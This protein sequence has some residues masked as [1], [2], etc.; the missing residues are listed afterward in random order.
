M[1]P[2]PLLGSAAVDGWRGIP[3]ATHHLETSPVM[4]TGYSFRNAGRAPK[5]VELRPKTCRTVI[6]NLWNGDP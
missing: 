6:R 1:V 3:G 5:G 2:V 4:D